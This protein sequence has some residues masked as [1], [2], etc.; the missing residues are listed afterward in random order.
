MTASS[1]HILGLIPEL[2]SDPI[3][4]LEG[5]ALRGD[6]VRF[7]IG[8]LPA[9]TVNDPDAAHQVLVG[10]RNDYIKSP[11]FDRLKILLGDGLVMTSRQEWRWDR[12]QLQPAFTRKHVEAQ[13]DDMVGV[14]TEWMGPWKVGDERDLADEML[15]LSMALLVGTLM[16]QVDGQSLSTLRTA[17][18]AAQ[19][20]LATRLWDLVAWPLFVP[21]R[22]N[23][24]FRE[25]R[26]SLLAELDRAIA[27]AGEGADLVA[28]ILAAKP[29][30]GQGRA[31]AEK[32]R[33]QLLTFLFAGH[34]TTSNSLGFLL[35]HLAV[36]P[37]VCATVRTELV[38]VL[39]DDSLSLRHLPKLPRTRAAIEEALRIHPTIWAFTRHALA[40][41]RIGEVLIPRGA[42]LLVSPWTLHRHPAHWRDPERYDPSRFARSKPR[43]GS[44]IPFGAGPRACVGDHFAMLEITAVLSVLLRRFALE[45]PAD[46]VLRPR[47]RLTVGLRGGLPTRLAPL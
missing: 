23:R 36:H 29:F 34:E 45:L 14:A 37:E 1:Q 47:A 20:E 30:P 24:R 19:D 33:D 25:A 27:K 7:R 2:R 3:A 31:P 40:E 44:F 35:Y 5:L 18:E 22:R 9:F 16:P 46:Y 39:G 6:V 32:V 26:A 43:K 42:T 12:R 28:T 8:P 13:L 21:T 15:G 17:F 11:L 38:E 10:Q 41:N 4:A